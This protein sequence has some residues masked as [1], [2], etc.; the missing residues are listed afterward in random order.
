MSMGRVAPIPN[1]IEKTV[2]IKKITVATGQRK[3]F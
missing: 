1:Q 2:P 3:G